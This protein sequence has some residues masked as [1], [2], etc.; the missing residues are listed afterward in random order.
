ME[1]ARPA[2]EGRFEG[3]GAEACEDGANEERGDGLNGGRRMRLEGAELDK[4]EAAIRREGIP[5][6]VDADLGAMGVA[7]AIHQ[8][9]AEEEVEERE[10]LRRAEIFG[11]GAGDLEFVERLE[12]G[13]VDARGLRTRA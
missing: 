1:L 8:E 9:V 7:R 4:A 5:E 3:R 10:V 11:A 2:D 6:F 13:F 12:G